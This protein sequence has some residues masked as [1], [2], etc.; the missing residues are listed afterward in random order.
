MRTTVTSHSEK[1]VAADVI[2][3]IASGLLLSI[4]MTIRFAPQALAARR[5]PVK[6]ASGNSRISR[7]SDVR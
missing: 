2:C 7:S 4:A 5:A 1:A 6:T 3:S